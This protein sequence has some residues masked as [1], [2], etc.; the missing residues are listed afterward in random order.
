[1]G[2][3]YVVSTL[4][5]LILCFHPKIGVGANCI[6]GKYHGDKNFGGTA[7]IT[8]AS[9]GIGVVYADRLARRGNEL[10][11]VARKRPGYGKKRVNQSKLQRPISAK[12]RTLPESSKY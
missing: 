2:G 9:G 10:I 8:G 7:L 1:L 3:F 5:N 12:R 4:D 11:L 6:G